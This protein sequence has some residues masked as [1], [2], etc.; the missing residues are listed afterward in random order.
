M[1]KQWSPPKWYFGSS[2]SVSSETDAVT[3]WVFE[4]TF[5]SIL[6][7]DDTITAPSWRDPFGVVQL[8]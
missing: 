2:V 5:H 6:E 4:R 1:T 7:E 3:A 8:M